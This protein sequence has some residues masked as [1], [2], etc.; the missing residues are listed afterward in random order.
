MRIGYLQK[1]S[2]S[3]YPGKI[4]AVIFTQGCNFRCPYCHNPELVNPN[5]RER[6]VP[7]EPVFSFLA[8]R[9]GLIDAVVIT[10][11][12]PSIQGD[13]VRFIERIRHM[14]YLV[15]LDTNG[16]RPDVLEK[17]LDRGYLDYIAMDIKA[18]IEKYGKVVGVPV[19]ITAVTASIE[20]IMKSGVDY[21]FRTTLPRSLLAPAD[22]VS[23][24]TMIE[25]ASRYV[26]QNF[27]ASKHV[28]KRF[29]NEKGFSEEELTRLVPLLENQVRQCLVR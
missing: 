9:R 5:R 24:G 19:N 1:S 4:S 18:P 10:G 2:V 6:P 20:V 17:L 26:L 27:V 21:E 22:I 12:E 8:K 28:D 13:L 16:S 7:L 11:G 29:V 25:G 3:D 14:G 23:I 15:K